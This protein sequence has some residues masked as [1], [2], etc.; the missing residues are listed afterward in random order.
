MRPA[1][2]D[3]MEPDLELKPRTGTRVAL[4]AGGLVFLAV[5]ALLAAQQARSARHAPPLVLI[6]VFGIA[7]ALM[8][9]LAIRIGHRRVRI[10][11]DG[12]EVHGLFDRKRLAWS[13][14]ASYSFVSVDTSAQVAYTQGGLI[15]LLVVAAV[16][17]LRTKPRDRKFQGGRLVLHGNDGSKLAIGPWFRDADRGLERIF[18]EIHPR[19]EPVLGTQFGKLTF[20]GNTLGYGSKEPLGVLEIEKLTVS[21]QGLVVVKKVGKRLPWVSVRMAGIPCSLLLFERLVQRGI[22]VEMPDAVYVPLPTLGVLTR[23]A[24]ARQNLPQARVQQR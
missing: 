13:D 17:K 6:V 19:L 3:A 11:R 4:A 23:M 2:D 16:K 5:A 21:P 18:A 12:I 10:D 20:D 22:F 7:A 15:G 1:Y 24:T 8:L 9:L 14:V